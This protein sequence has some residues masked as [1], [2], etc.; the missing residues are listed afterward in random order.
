[1]K[2]VRWIVPEA[3][4]PSAGPARSPAAASAAAA[5]QRPLRVGWLDNSKDNAQL[6]LARIAAVV[7]RE[8]V[9]ESIHRRK[10]AA[11]LGAPV[12][13]LEDLAHEADCVLTAMAD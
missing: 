9:A 8:I 10:N 11:T 3:K 1:M 4:E 5:R 7:Q 2:R 6:L 13:I 12:E